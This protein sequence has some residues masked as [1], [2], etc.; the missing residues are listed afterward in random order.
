MRRCR[1]SASDSLASCVDRA[2]EPAKFPDPPRQANRFEGC[3]QAWIDARRLTLDHNIEG[4]IGGI[5]MAEH[6]LDHRCE[7]RRIRRLRMPDAVEGGK[8]A[9][10]PRG[11]TK[12]R[13]GRP[14]P[15][16]PDR[17]TRPLQRT[18]AEDSFINRVVA[19]VV[20]EHLAAP[21]S[22]QDRQALIEFLRAHACGGILAKGSELLVRLGPQ[23]RT[24]NTATGES[25]QKSRIAVLP[26]VG[27][28]DS[29]VHR[30]S[31]DSGHT[32]AILDPEPQCL[33]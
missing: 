1:R 29:A 10:P 30:S 16:D 3:E 31:A 4:R 22:N 7:L 13:P 6:V 26:D 12:W 5:A 8:D 23:T 27:Q 9:V 19:A 21:Q 24:N 25:Y 28:S 11:A 14:A 20:R 15:C 2:P 18:R 32:R 33:R 17:D